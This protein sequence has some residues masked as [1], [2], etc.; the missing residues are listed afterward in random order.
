MIRN[1]LPRPEWSCPHRRGGIR[2]PAAAAL[3]ACWTALVVAEPPRALQAAPLPFD[4]LPSAFEAWL[5]AR[6]GWPDGAELRFSGLDRCLDR[7]RTSSPYS[8]PLY[9]CLAGTVTIRDRSG[10][11]TCQLSQVLF[12]P[13]TNEVRYRTLTCR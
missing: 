9:Q 13:R 12:L 5:N 10:S 3:L 4:P 8:S 7:S 6:R 1:A 11:R 2:F